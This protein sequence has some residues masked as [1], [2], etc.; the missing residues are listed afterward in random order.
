VKVVA[1]VRTE[2]SA[3]KRG[4]DQVLAALHRLLPRVAVL[5]QGVFACDLRGTARLLGSPL[6]V[7][8]RMAAACER[9]G[10]PGAVGIAPT[11][12]AAQVLAARTGTGEVSEE[13][14]VL[15]F[16][17]PLP[18]SVLPLD[19]TIVD[20]LALLG[21]HAVGGFAQLERGSVLD[22]FGA[23]GLHAH[24][25]ARAED[26][27][28]IHGAAPRRRIRARRRFEDPISS[29][30]Q[31]VFALRTIVESVAAA[32]ANDGLA[33][34]RLALHLE[35]ERAGP[36][37]LDRLLLPPT[38]N[39]ATLLRSLRWAL[40][41]WTGIGQ[42]V[43]ALIEAIEVEPLRGRQLGLFAP[44]GAHAEEALAVAQHLR[45]RLGAG[46]VLRA[47][48]IAPDA[49]LPEREAEWSEVV[50]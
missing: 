48:V 46:V 37:R 17:S 47:R 24:A 11:A 42:V 39:A 21:I 45:G 23:A 26:E 10:A 7:G 35:R 34:L 40:D 18:V 2:R 43:G 22:R 5:D 50:A 13:S 49:R 12:F 33:A 16:L 3:P 28:E 29:A 36:L 27:T 8:R 1:V 38:A 41:E 6:A 15:G 4:R 9:A 19:A 30:E 20:E 31:L 14:D 44:D 25:L 32:L